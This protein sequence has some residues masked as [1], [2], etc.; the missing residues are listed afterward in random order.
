MGYAPI[1]GFFEEYYFLSNFSEEGG[2]QP[3]VEHWYQAGKAANENEAAKIMAA[4]TPGKAKKLGRRCKL[5]PDWEE[6][7][8][9]FMRELLYEKFE[10][11]TVRAKLVAMA[12]AVMQTF[13][14]TRNRSVLM[15]YGR[16]WC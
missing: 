4:P 11:P 16:I 14:R 10:E 3:T 9:D 12:V 2:V 5:R 6:I 13:A 15:L 1:E 7:K 8:V